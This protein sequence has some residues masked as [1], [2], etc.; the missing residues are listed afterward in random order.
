MLELLNFYPEEVTNAVILTAGE[1][2]R[3]LLDS[4]D[5]PEYLH[6]FLVMAVTE[7]KEYAGIIRVALEQYYAE[8]HNMQTQTGVPL[9]LHVVKAVA[10][11]PLPSRVNCHWCNDAY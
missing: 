11:P 5:R 10:E 1:P 6:E 7:S 4:V 9:C 3:R 2:G 8:K